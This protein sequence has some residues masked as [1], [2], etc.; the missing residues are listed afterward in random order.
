[1]LEQKV[2]FNTPEDLEK[3]KALIQEYILD[4]IGAVPQDE[5]WRIQDVYDQ[6][7]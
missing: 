6:L 4:R 2:L 1:M 7:A 5:K 3:F